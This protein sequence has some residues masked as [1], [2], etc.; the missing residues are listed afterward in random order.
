MVR[1]TRRTAIHCIGTGSVL[2]LA[3]CTDGAQPGAGDGGDGSD[4]TDGADGSDGHGDD[5]AEVTT[6][7]RQVGTA[8]SGGEWDRAGRRGFCALI[9]DADESASWPFGEAPEGVRA[10]VEETNFAESVLVYVESVGPTTCHDEI[11]FDGIG[12]GVEDGTFVADATVRGAGNDGTV[13]GEAI[14]Y[15]AALLRVTSDPLPDAVRLSLT[16]GWSETGT[17]RDAD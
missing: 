12:M 6:V 9:T 4:G 7:V 3:G 11:A 14:T 16:D 17:V 1:L 13:C 5:G 10:F 2:A 15:P 8:L